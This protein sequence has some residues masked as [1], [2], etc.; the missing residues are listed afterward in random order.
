VL[1]LRAVLA[2]ALTVLR[3]ALFPAGVAL[4]RAA[5]TGADLPLVLEFR[6]E[7]AEVRRRDER[8]RDE[9]VV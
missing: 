9:H 8:L 1:A 5:L 4:L 2:P 3:A 6:F 7:E